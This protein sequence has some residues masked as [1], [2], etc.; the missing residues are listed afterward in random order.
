METL[1]FNF[2]INTVRNKIAILVVAIVV[3]SLLFW[4]IDFITLR[5]DYNTDMAKNTALKHAIEYRNKVQNEINKSLNA[6]ESLSKILAS[7][8]NIKENPRLSRK[9]VNSIL[10]NFLIANQNFTAVGLF[11]EPNGFDN[12]DKAFKSKDIYG[13]TGIFAAYWYK[14]SQNRVDYTPYLEGYISDFYVIPKKNKRPM[15]I[16]PHVFHSKGKDILVTTIIFPI[17]YNGR[18]YGI[19]TID[20]FTKSLERLIDLA[21]IYNSKTKM[22]IIANEGTIVASTAHPD[23]VGFPLKEIYLDHEEQIVEIIRER[24]KIEI[25][26]EEL[27][28]FVPL[29]FDKILTPWQFRLKIPENE[30]NIYQKKE[31]KSNYFIYTII[32]IV[33]LGGTIYLVNWHLIP[34]KNI[35]YI[36]DKLG[37]GDVSFKKQ[38]RVTGDEFLHIKQSFDKLIKSYRYVSKFADEIG[39]GNLDIDFKSLGDKDVLGNSLIEMRNSLYEAKKIDEKRKEEDEKRNWS[40]EGLARFNEILRTQSDNVERL[41][42]KIMEGLVNYI[43]VNQGA[44]FIYNDDDQDDPFLELVVA[45]AY[46][47]RR[48]IK[49][50]IKPGEGLLGTCALEKQTMFMS[51]IPDDYIEITSGLGTANPNYLLIVP[52]VINKQIFGIVELA[53]FYDIKPHEVEFVEKLAESIA[54][55]ISVTKVNIRTNKLLK[56]SKQ[57]S[58]E[59]AAQEEEM[60]QN[61]EELKA[62]QEEMQRKE[63]LLKELAVE[64]K[65]QEEKLIQKLEKYR[66]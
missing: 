17:L 12:N 30:I 25:E 32:L 64:M 35:S 58:E 13:R 49:R 6:A 45:I 1:F 61:L 33:L 48:F 34:L 5:N 36:A 41:A 60:R 39:S 2:N 56:L 53:S 55:T 31:V 18:F 10:K 7:A 43:N 65:M 28:V 57:Q 42:Y 37:E 21:E 51:K 40:T 26:N 44:L 52:L 54:S 62:T 29:K 3:I 14:S 23:F 9:Q 27:A 63:K 46:N 66:S 4:F 50:K 59:L 38:I 24:T 11:W 16:P 20:I 47:E 8:K 19:V 22:A 15:I